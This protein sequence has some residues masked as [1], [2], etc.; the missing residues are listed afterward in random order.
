MV[1]NKIIHDMTIAE[2]SDFWDEHEF[3]EFSDTEEVHDV[4]FTLKRKKY[5]GI[6][7]D[8]YARVAAQAQQLHTTAER[9]I[10]SWVAEKVTS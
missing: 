5:V 6:D 1:N 9:L 2:A 4:Q 3:A 8:V 7:A 10:T